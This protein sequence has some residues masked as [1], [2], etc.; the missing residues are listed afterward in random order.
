[1]FKS[2]SRVAL[3]L[4]LALTGAAPALAGMSTADYFQRI[5][6]LRA[7]Q[8]NPQDAPWVRV[9]VNRIALPARSITV[10]HGP[11][12]KIDMP[13]MTMTWTVADA[14]HLAMLHKGDPV[15][16]QLDKRDGVVQVVDFR[17]Q[18]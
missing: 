11:I 15:D 17:M 2:K 3:A 8:T 5:E 12:A 6:K 4:A 18:R 16:I 9:T 13:A 1:M 7:T 10:S 14:T